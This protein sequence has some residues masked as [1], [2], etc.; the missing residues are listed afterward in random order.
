MIFSKRD[1]QN[2]PP[3]TFCTH[4]VENVSVHRHLGVYLTPTL[5]WSTHVHQVCLKAN[6]KLAVLRSVKQ[7]S[8]STLDLLYKLTV[9]SLIDYAMPVNYGN[10][11]LTEKKRLEQIQNRAAKLVTGTLHYTSQLKLFLELGWETL[12]T[13]FDCLGLGLFHKIHLGHTRPLIKTFMSEIDSQIYNTCVHIHYKRFPYINKQ[14]AS[15]FY[16]YFTNKLNSSHKTLK[17]E[18]DIN[19]YKIKLKNIYRPRKYKFYYRGST[20]VGCS[21]LT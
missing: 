19:E 14:F 16:P 12:Q 5:D 2:S 13:R 18:R 3:I 8:R 11:K 9:R 15:S 6:R 1:Q 21:Y 20:K 4:I 10:L 7:L 17:N